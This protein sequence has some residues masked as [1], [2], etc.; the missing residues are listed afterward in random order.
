[1]KKATLAIGIIALFIG[2]AVMSASATIKTDSGNE[3]EH[4]PFASIY[5]ENGKIDA[6]FVGIR[7]APITKASYMLFFHGTVK[8]GS[9][10]IN[11]GSVQMYTLT[12]GDEFKAFLIN[13]WYSPSKWLDIGSTTLTEL[14]GMPIGLQVLD[15]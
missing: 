13:A 3:W 8:E 11:S 10:R 4:V 15:K 6:D 9:V 2:M 12:E 7:Y 1:M 14:Q 5:M